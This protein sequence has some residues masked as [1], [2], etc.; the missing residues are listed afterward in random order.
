MNP[1]QREAYA[2]PKRDKE[3]NTISDQIQAFLERGGKIELLGSGFDNARD[4]KCKL[5]EDM[6]LFA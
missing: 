1:V 2:T 5:G 6:G 3:S 4:P